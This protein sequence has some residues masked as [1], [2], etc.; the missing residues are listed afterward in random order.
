MLH[1]PLQTLA[2]CTP[3][4]H[5]WS[6]NYHHTRFPTLLYLQCTL[7]PFPPSHLILQQDEHLHG[8]YSSPGQLHIEIMEE[9]LD[10]PTN[11]YHD[12]HLPAGI[13]KLN[14]RNMISIIAMTFI[15]ICS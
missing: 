6:S 1:C 3:H 5:L 14:V 13:L 9:L 4:E 2:A 8:N 11:F 10:F 7:P 12:I 15:I